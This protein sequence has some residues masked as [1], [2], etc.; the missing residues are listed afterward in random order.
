MPLTAV[1]WLLPIGW[2]LAT[3]GFL[4]PWIAHPTAALSLSGG[5][6][7][8]FVKFLP[9][10]LDG[11]L[12]LVRQLFYLPP[13]AVTVSIALLVGFDGLHYARFLRAAALL[14][15]VLLSLQLLPPAWSPSSLLTA[16]FRTQ[17][18]ALGICWLLLVCFWLMRRLPAWLLGSLSAA[19]S[20]LAIVLPAW[21]FLVA[22][23][24]IDNVYGSPPGAGWGMIL[25]FTG[26]AVVAAASA[27][28]ALSRRSQTEVR[29]T[30]GSIEA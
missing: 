24:A 9:G 20:V 8:E 21:Q 1:R 5:D 12:R 27:V 7:A 30:S 4:G 28:S 23:P 10:V 6:M 16:E 11:S 2:G 13:F 26:L 22:K 15:A 29:K 3:L 14:L 19:L 18:V 17:T 25:C